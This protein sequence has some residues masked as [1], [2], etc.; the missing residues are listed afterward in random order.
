[1]KDGNLGKTGNL[2]FFGGGKIKKAKV[3]I[4]KKIGGLYSKDDSNFFYMK[5]ITLFSFSLF[6]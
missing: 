6:L 4:G 5:G 2:I 3:K 1:L